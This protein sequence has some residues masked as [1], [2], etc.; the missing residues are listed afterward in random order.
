M[1]D[2]R[3]L[4]EALV[5]A[6]EAGDT[7]N[8]QILAD[9]I[10]RA[11]SGSSRKASVAAP[12]G[13]AGAPDRGGSGASGDRRLGNPLAQIAAEGAKQFAGAAMFPGELLRAGANAFA[14]DP[15]EFG[16]GT[17]MVSD[18]IDSVVT[19]PESK[20]GKLATRVL[21]GGVASLA[22]PGSAV[23]NFAT[24]A[25]GA[26]GSEAGASGGKASRL[27]GGEVAG[28]VIGG[29]V[30]GAPLSI[31]RGRGTKD[32]MVHE[33]TK[34][35]TKGDFAAAKKLQ[36]EAN[37]L[38]IHLTPEQLFGTQSGLDELFRETVRSGAG[39]GN[40]QTLV[41]KQGSEAEALARNS[42]NRLGANVGEEAATRDLRLSAERLIGDVART[43]QANTRNFQPGQA[44]TV[45]PQQLAYLDSR[46]GE[47]TAGFAASPDTQKRIQSVRDLIKRVTETSP[48][49]DTPKIV[50]REGKAGKRILVP[51][52]KE[53]P[54]GARPDDLDLIVKEAKAA[55]DDLGI[56]TPA[57]ARLMTGRTA[58]AFNEVRDLLD[59]ITPTRVAGR[60]IFGQQ[61]E[62][63]DAL[64]SSL[65]G[66]LAGKSGVNEA[67]PDNL[68]LLRSTLN[69]DKDQQASIAT[70]ASALRKQATRGTPEERAQAA[71]SLPQ[72]ARAV[73]DEVV[74]R[75]FTPVS[76]RT[77]AAG[78]VTVAAELVGPPTKEKN[79]RQL[80][81][82]VAAAYGGDAKALADGMLS[83]L[84]VLEA[85]GRNRGGLNFAAGDIRQSVG[86]STVRDAYRLTQPLAQTQVLTEKLRN[87]AYER[88]YRQLADIFSNPNAL[89]L[90]EEIGR[91]PIV[92][93]R[94]GAMV[95][96]LMQMLQQPE[97]QGAQQ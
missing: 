94:Q 63:V 56:A 38:G 23:R 97:Q 90:V 13:A 71:R 21:G 78:G 68:N 72:A 57:T 9:E 77:P 18:A 60:E 28:G 30:G 10:K 81:S 8:A 35:L 87:M 14:G 44:A 51:A 33:A 1:S 36:D 15:V 84:K 11:S 65:I 39:K 73:W 41:M 3:A 85:S 64:R 96:T 37:L 82:G 26:A 34:G 48:V 29:F 46:L 54:I 42:G 6:H 88:Q 70:L 50:T 89:A 16:R 47:L 5:R 45:S 83:V 92:S 4:E 80:M 7:A 79:F 32:Q 58:G 20:A 31:A 12:A 2:I 43:T 53:V 40:L 93:S 59:K 95:S 49:P 91:T 22:F 86:Q 55:L 27:P 61:Q 76:G 66:R 24:G 25:G 67:A 69:S 75:A 74:D 17:Q 52:T 19:P 62:G